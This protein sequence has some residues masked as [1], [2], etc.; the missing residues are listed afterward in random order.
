MHVHGFY[1]NRFGIYN[2][3]TCFVKV[4]GSRLIKTIFGSG[5]RK[6]EREGKERKEKERKEKERNIKS[7][8]FA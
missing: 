3:K 2:Q 8:I 5:L 6:R 4:R 7:L 1:L